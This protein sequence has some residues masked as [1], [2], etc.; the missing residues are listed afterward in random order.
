[1][2]CPKCGKKAKRIQGGYTKTE[3]LRYCMCPECCYMFR[4]LEV[5]QGSVD[6]DIDL[7]K[8]HVIKTEPLTRTTV[9]YRIMPGSLVKFETLESEV[10]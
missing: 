5:I 1:M 6:A 3:V 10:K 9:R 8:S 2:N 7:R 4:S